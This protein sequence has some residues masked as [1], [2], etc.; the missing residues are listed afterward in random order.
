MVENVDSAALTVGDVLGVL[1]LIASV[2]NET[3][4]KLI[5]LGKDL[6]TLVKVGSLHA[7]L[8]ENLAS[9][10]VGVLI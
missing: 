4:I 6:L 7:W 3:V 2:A 10:R 9:P 1:V 8:L 5:G